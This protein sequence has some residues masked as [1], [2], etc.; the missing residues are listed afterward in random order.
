MSR[1][2]GI[3]P[4]Q[5]AQVAG[6]VEFLGL[7]GKVSLAILGVSLMGYAALLWLNAHRRKIKITET[8]V[9][10]IID[11]IRVV[12]SYSLILA[13]PLSVVGKGS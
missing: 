13:L 10:V 6:W 12:G 7:P 1:S 5:T 2:I 4:S 8:W 3:S 9:A 11:V